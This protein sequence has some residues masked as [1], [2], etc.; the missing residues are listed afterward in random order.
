MFE[1]NFANHLTATAASRQRRVDHLARLCHLRDKWRA[2]HMRRRAGLRV[3]HDHVVAAR[4]QLSKLFDLCH[5]TT[6][7]IS[8][9]AN[10][11]NC[12]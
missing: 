8:P 4:K 2:R 11:E 10:S 5:K 9:R 7:S 3:A 1:E 6:H 12:A